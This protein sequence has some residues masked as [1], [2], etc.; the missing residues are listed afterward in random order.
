M[1]D[2]EGEIRLFACKSTDDL[3]TS[4]SLFSRLIDQIDSTTATMN[5]TA[6]AVTATNLTTPQQ[7]STSLTTETNLPIHPTQLHQSNST[8]RLAPITNSHQFDMRGG[9]AA[10]AEVKLTSTQQHPK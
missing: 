9:A 2:E 5:A 8:T 1:S 3:A 4:P 10:A 7:P 6:A